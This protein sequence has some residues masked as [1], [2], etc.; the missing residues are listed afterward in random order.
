M[1]KD[2]LKA[3]AK[4]PTALDF[5]MTPGTEEMIM[6]IW[7]MIMIKTDQAMVVKRPR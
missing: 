5:S 4:A 1:F 7:P 2:V 3:T 6:M